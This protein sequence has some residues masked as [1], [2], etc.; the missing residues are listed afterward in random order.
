LEPRDEVRAAR[1][2]PRT[3]LLLG[4]VW[5][6]EVIMLYDAY[7]YNNLIELMLLE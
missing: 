1:C 2:L 6:T 4:F 7:A 5:D 3:C